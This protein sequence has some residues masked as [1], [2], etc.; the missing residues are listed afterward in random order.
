MPDSLNLFELTAL[1]LVMLAGLVCDVVLL[2]R[3]APAPAWR[4]TT[5]L[6]GMPELLMAAGAVLGVT[7]LSSALYTVTNAA[8]TVIIPAELVLRFAM[9]AGFFI[10]FRR[11]R[12]AIAP[13][14]GLDALTPRKAIG[15]G[16]V[17]ALASQP[18]V[19]LMIYGCDTLYR[20]VG[21]KPSEQ[22]ITELFTTT[23]SPLLLTTITVFAIVAAPVFEEFLF[24]G[25]AYPALKHRVGTGRA[26]AIVS[27]AFAF[28][29]LHMPSV[30]PLFVLALALGLAYELTGSLLTSI[31]MHATFNGLMIVRL[32]Y[33]RAHP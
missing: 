26:L 24:R 33:Q 21:I 2:R 29:H 1:S 4:V 9:L 20:L 10:F 32:F 7:V 13:A 16:V 31:T 17:F 14:L 15:W 23:D 19:G 22:P 6:W 8:M 18:P 28:S 27:A 3:F 25:F 11:R 5:G 30:I 12:I